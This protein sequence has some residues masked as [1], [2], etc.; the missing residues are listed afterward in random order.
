MGDRIIVFTE[1]PTNIKKEFKNRK[2]VKNNR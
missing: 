1:K 2:V